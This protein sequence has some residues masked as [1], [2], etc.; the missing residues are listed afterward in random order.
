[1]R[2]AICA[3]K[4]FVAQSLRGSFGGFIAKIRFIVLARSLHWEGHP[5]TSRVCGVTES[6]PHNQKK[7]N[8]IK[9]HHHSVRDG[10][11]VGHQRE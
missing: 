7:S 9:S 5:V 10:G 11:H 4:N 8:E 6:K 3:R 1:V 2:R